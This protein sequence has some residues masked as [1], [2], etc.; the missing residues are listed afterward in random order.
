[1]DR[2][3][4]AGNGERVALYLEGNDEGEGSSLTY[5]RLLA[6]VCRVANY[7]ASVGV[8]KGDRVVIYLPMRVELPIA[9]L[10]CAR[11]GAIHSVVFGGFSADALA[12]RIVDSTPKVVVTVTAVKR[13]AKPIGLKSTV[14]D[15]LRM[16]GEQGVTVPLVLVAEN[17]G[18]MANG[19]AKWVAGRDVWW[20]DCVPKQAATAPV[21][22]VDAE[23]P[24]FMLY[25]SGSTGKPKGVVHSTGGYMVYSATTFKY[26]F[27]YRPGDVYWCTADCGWITGHSYLTYGPLLC[28]ATQVM[29][30]GAFHECAHWRIATA[31]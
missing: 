3:V 6:E 31:A 22:W 8:T 27:D 17:P 15:A 10:A 20:G 21:T 26:V 12:Q 18:A 28:G 19:D 30:E 24:L 9:M 5:A 14:D 13:G 4:E 16:A 2:H 23:H 11:L 25:T 7:L 1:M 29:F